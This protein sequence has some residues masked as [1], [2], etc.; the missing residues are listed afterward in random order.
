MDFLNFQKQMGEQYGTSESDWAPLKKAAVVRFDYDEKNN[1]SGQ[2]NRKFVY[3]DKDH[4]TEFRAGD[5]WLVSL[6]DNPKTYAN[7]FAIPLRKIDASFLYEMIKDQLDSFALSLWENNRTI[8]EPFLDEKYQDIIKERINKAVE[9]KTEE[10]NKTIE[11]LKNDLDELGKINEQDK[12]II[13]SNEEKIELLTAQIT[14]LKN[15]PAKIST[16]ASSA[17]EQPRPQTDFKEIAEPQVSLI[18][19]SGPDSLTSESFTKSRY[20]VHLSADHKMLLIREDKNGTVICMD[21]TLIL[22]GLS[23]ILPYNEGDVLSGE[24]SGKFGG[25]V[26]YLK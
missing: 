3:P 7:Y 9:E 22:S 12:G 17:T 20:F 21:N 23:S 26:V 14:V 11:T 1:L 19:R 4:T 10:L 2:Y 15:E 16:A 18:E 25:I 13:Q 8:L 24:Y 5:I 6:S